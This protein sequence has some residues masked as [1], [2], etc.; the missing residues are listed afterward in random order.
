M[1]MRIS[2]AGALLLLAACAES[3]SGA[4]AAPADRETIPCALDGA[5]SFDSECW[6]EGDGKSYRPP[7]MFRHPDGGFRRFVWVY[8]DPGQELRTAD[9][10]QRAEVTVRELA[11]ERGLEI[12]VDNHRYFRPVESAEE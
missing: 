4:E 1:S 5:A 2:N 6:L 7:F 3:G 12:R 9:G 10:A 11:Q 8:L